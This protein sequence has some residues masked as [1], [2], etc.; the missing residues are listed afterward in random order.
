MRQ[1]AEQ[2]EAR[3]VALRLFPRNVLRGFLAVS[4][5]FLVRLSLRSFEKDDSHVFQLL[6]HKLGLATSSFDTS[7]YLMGG[8]EFDF[9]S[10]YFFNLIAP[11][12]LFLFA[13]VS[14][15]LFLLLSTDQLLFLNRLC[16]LS[17]GLYAALSE[18]SLSLKREP[19]LGQEEHRAKAEKARRKD[20][21]PSTQHCAADTR[22]SSADDSKLRQRKPVGTNEREESPPPAVESSDSVGEKR[23][24]A[25]A[26]L[27]AQM[28]DQL[29]SAVF[30]MP[31]LFYLSVQ[32]IFFVVL[33]LLI[34]RLRVLALPLLCVL[35]AA[36]ASPSLWRS[37]ACTLA[38][39]LN[40]PILASISSRLTGGRR[41]RSRFF[42]L[43]HVLLF[44]G[45]SALPFYLKLPLEEMIVAEP[46]TENAA[47]QSRLSLINWLKTNVPP[48]AAILGDMP[49][50]STL[51]A[52]TQ[53]R[54]VIHPQFEQAEMRKRV[55]FLYG[56]SACP[57][58]ELYA[59]MMQRVYETDY[60]LINNF[61]CAA[62]KQNKVTVFGVAD[63]VEEKSFPCPR[64]V[65]SF[66]RFCFKTQLSSA[67]FDLLYRNGVYAVLKVKEP[68]GTRAEGKA[69][70][71]SQ[72]DRKEAEK[73][74]KESLR[75]LDIQKKNEAYLSF[76]WK[77]K[78]STLEA[79]DPWIQ[80][81]ITDDER[82]GRNMQEFAQ[83]LMDLYGLKVTS[84][85]LQEK[86]VSLFPDHSDVL[87]GHG[88]FLDFDMGNS[89]D[90]AT[91]Y[92]RGADKDPLSVAKT[93]QFLLF[94]DQAIGRSRAVEGVSRLLHLEDILEK[95]TNAELL[96][97]ATNLCKAA[98]LLKQLVDT[99]VKQGASRDTPHA[100]QEQERVM[101]RIWDRSKEL[102]IQNECVV[103]GWAYFEN[104]RLTTAR[105]IQHFFFG[106][107]R[108]LSRVIRAVS[109]FI[110][111]LL[112][113]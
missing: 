103:E 58:E 36:V 48:D 63:L 19:L 31:D 8:T 1:T 30:L 68:R 54:L 97:D 112:L 7:I 85:L 80:R 12:R 64:A 9:F 6:L 56:A 37:V 61:R 32:A 73:Q 21:A 2:G 15:L 65:E 107:S 84:R 93:V 10:L 72:S 57:P 11:S 44:A 62:A 40:L 23:R 60:L 43:V 108:F 109:L 14:L 69:A 29:V 92:E 17:P 35:A 81:C 28:E 110:N 50:S 101:Q 59:S 102:N 53:L 42:F 83:E 3:G 99:Q 33:M 113:S 94:L 88:V 47:N 45:F 104:S 51:R 55:Q 20:A 27:R 46:S 34:A 52:A 79:L 5:C 66:S 90:A 96:D 49:S 74:L 24:R 41:C 38:A 25:E 89:K 95:K 86:S 106:E 16:R 82:C 70:T 75:V 13:S 18:E 4:I 67:S 22:V 100:I 87:F 26:R 78:V 105:R 111:T 76:D 77:S 39:S 71:R 91:Y 98:L